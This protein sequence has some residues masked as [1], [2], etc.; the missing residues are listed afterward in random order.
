[1]SCRQA[2]NPL[3]FPV[4]RLWPSLIRLLCF[5]LLFPVVGYS[6]EARGMHNP[7]SFIVDPATGIY[8]ISN[9]NG[10][11]AAKDNN[12]FISKLDSSGQMLDLTFIAGGRDQVVLNAPKG[13]AILGNDLYV[14]DIDMVQRFDKNTGHLLGTID[15]KHVGAG[16]LRAVAADAKGNIF[17]SDT[18]GDMIF[19][20]V[21]ARNFQ[22]TILAKGTHLGNPGGLVY[23]PVSKRLIAA[24]QGSGKIL[25]VDMNG[26]TMILFNGELKG[27]DG[28]DFDR[29]GNLLASSFTEGKIYRIKKYSTVEVIR[30]NIITPAG[31]SFD[32]KN[33]QILVP[34]FNGNLVFTHLLE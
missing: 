11:S 7:E 2:F 33:N 13:L 15:L 31:I 24:A 27:L 8:Y 22:V 28:I 26:K 30:E 12:G 16:F 5:F 23:D 20:I 14:A 1:M 6:F 3:R 10:A 25:S 9:V 32:Y 17:V 29:N 18:N 4:S 21:P 19:Q 34:S